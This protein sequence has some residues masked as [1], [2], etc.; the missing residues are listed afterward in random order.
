MLFGSASM[1]S[2]TASGAVPEQIQRVVR[3][4]QVFGWTTHASGCA[5]VHDLMPQRAQRLGLCTRLQSERATGGPK[6]TGSLRLR[7][8][9]PFR[10]KEALNA[11][12]HEPVAGSCVNWEALRL[13]SI[14]ATC[15]RSP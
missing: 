13:A 5:V 10:R 7:E 8:S 2:N 9:A 4:L 12:P 6:R 3:E 11:Q 1:S 15:Q 14:A